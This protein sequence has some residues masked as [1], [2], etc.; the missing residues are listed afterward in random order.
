MLVKD[1]MTPLEIS[2]SPRDPVVKAWRLIRKHGTVGLPVV[3]PDGQIVGVVTRDDIIESGPEI[4]ARPGAAVTSLMRDRVCVLREDSSLVDAWALHGKVFPVVDKDGRLIGLLD[5]YR[6]VV[7]LFNK[8]N[9]ILLQVDTILDS[10]NNGI[11]AINNQGIISLY[12]RAAEKMT[13]RPKSYAMGRH[14]SEVINPQGLLDY[15]KDGQSQ[16]ECKP[17][18]TYTSGNRTYLTNRS[19]I[20][21]NGQIVG[22]VAIF[23]DISEVE[24]IS[25]ELKSVK[26][27]NTKLELIIESSYDGILLTDP[28]GTILKANRA[29]ERIT[30]VPSSE[31]LG[32]NMADLVTAGV[33]SRS[34]VDAVMREGKPVTMVEKKHF[35]ITGSPVRDHD[36]KV[37]RIV[38]NIRDLTE[39]NNLREQLEQTKELSERYQDELTQ[40]RGKLFNQ[41]GLVFHSPKMRELLQVASRL[42][43]VDSTVLIL[44]ESGVGKEIIARTIHSQSKRKDGPFITVNCG[45]IPENLLESELFG[46]ER[47]AFTGANREGK[48][49]M[50]EL[51]HNGTLFLD[52][53]GELPPGFQVKLL[54]VIQERE[55]LRVGGSK[56]RPV[57]VRILAATNRCLETMVKEGRFREDLYFRINVVPLK[58]WP[59]RERK[60]DIIPLVHAFK[61]RYE[62]K[63]GIQKKIDPRV[64]EAFL[65]YH[66]P[67]NV[68]ELDNMIERLMVTTPGS[69]ITVS[70]LPS[71][72]FENL[73]QQQPEVYVKGIMP[74]KKAVM[75][76]ESQ[77][78]SNAIKEF[79]SANKAARVLK[80]DQSTLTRKISRLRE[81]GLAI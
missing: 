66:W 78:I 38:V 52:E 6:V 14:L 33:Y 27:L 49:G 4:L 3:E 17:P 18:I 19:S 40:L 73:G 36:G 48:A 70:D 41:E 23:Q 26:Q 29:H 60:E 8:A 75:Q 45:A 44:G 10:V 13:R 37:L 57:N 69:E 34:I 71:Y 35:L 9:W 28:E 53:I 31:I 2:L 21:E 39:L 74:L 67:G 24:Q 16:S 32:K 55:V 30:G 63:Y 22:A 20:Y 11:I 76:L 1:I 42:A 47:G 65:N 68:R 56:P 72:V 61:Q 25:Q 77:L 80:V 81:H 64:Y 62:N 7:E 51:A 54:R 15:L 46:Y 5:K 50:F 59:L 12:N 58:I 79:G 43:A